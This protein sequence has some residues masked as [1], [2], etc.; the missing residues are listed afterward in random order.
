M[1]PFEPRSAGN[2]SRETS[3]GVWPAGDDSADIFPRH[4]PIYAV[5]A[6]CSK[7]RE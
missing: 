1:N 5:F 7:C 2:A 4:H 6:R 3:P